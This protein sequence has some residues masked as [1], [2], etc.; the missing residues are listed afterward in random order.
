LVCLFKNKNSDLKDEV[1]KTSFKEEGTVEE[2]DKQT[3]E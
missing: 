3:L 2:K 1:L